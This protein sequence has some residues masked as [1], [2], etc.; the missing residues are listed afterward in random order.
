MDT[1][2]PKIDRE[3]TGV[4]IIDI[5]EK[6]FGH[7]EQNESLEKTLI[8][9]IKAFQLL[10]IPLI[11]SEQYPEG[12]GPTLASIYSL[13][14]SAPAFSKTT[15]SCLKDPIIK[16]EVLKLQKKTWVLLGIEAHICI[17]QTAKDLVRQGIHVIVPYEAVGSRSTLNKELALQEM[18]GR[19]VSVLPLES[20]LFECL[21]SS[22]ASSFKEIS[23]LV[24]EGGR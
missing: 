15:F 18:R 23:K 6:L 1:T 3:S 21:L 14:D 16:E 20:I 12:L 13:L 4:F 10:N 2:W 24:K 9:A 7:I 19:G 22:K 11:I 8:Q 17:L 5:Q